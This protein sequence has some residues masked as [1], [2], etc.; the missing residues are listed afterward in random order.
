MSD[1]QAEARHMKCDS[2]DGPPIFLA[3]IRLP[4]GETVKVCGTCRRKVVQ[5]DAET[6]NGAVQR[7]K[8]N[9]QTFRLGG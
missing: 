3:A 5:L 2:C 7:T 4:T 6:E 9:P 8:E 1:G